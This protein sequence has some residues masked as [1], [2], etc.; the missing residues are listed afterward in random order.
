MAQ[1]EVVPLRAD[2]IY[3]R[4]TVYP[5]CRNPT[6]S[7]CSDCPHHVHFL[8][9]P[10]ISQC[11]RGMSLLHMYDQRI[12]SGPLAVCHRKLHTH[13]YLW[14]TPSL[15][16]PERPSALR[17]DTEKIPRDTWLHPRFPL[18]H[19]MG[20]RRARLYS[21]DDW[22]SRLQCLFRGISSKINCLVRPRSL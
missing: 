1:I 9:V 5:T 12:T 20:Y 17:L 6:T 16:L 14:H 3:T 8:S 21:N 15:Y 19:S 7:N 13:T 2:T 22:P 4:Y 18:A 11:F 10:C